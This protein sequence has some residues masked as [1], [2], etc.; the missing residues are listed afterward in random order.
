MA[1]PR[2]TRKVIVKASLRIV[3]EEGL[4]AFSMRR[5]GVELKANPMAVYYHFPNKAALLDGLVEAVMSEIDLEIDDTSKEVDE[6]IYAAMQEYRRVLLSHPRALRVVTSRGIS[7]QTAF[8]PVELLLA[9]LGEAGLAP[10]D[11]LSAVN[12]LAAFVRGAVTS[13]VNSTLEAELSHSE[14]QS[15]AARASALQEML[16]PDEFPILSKMM[17]S[18]ASCFVGFDEEFERGIRALIR[19]LLLELATDKK[20][21]REVD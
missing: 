21:A 10:G 2:L 1:R 12:I 5:L 14:I 6:R 7:T 18:S 8:R 9:I 11:A 3:D 4:E 13:Q 20:S 17:C 15:T 19:G 16:P